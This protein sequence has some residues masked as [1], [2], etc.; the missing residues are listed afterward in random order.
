VATE[1]NTRWLVTLLSHLNK[2]GAK[3]VPRASTSERF[4]ASR[5]AARRKKEATCLNKRLL[6]SGIKL[7]IFLISSAQS[8]VFSEMSKYYCYHC[9]NFF[10]KY[11]YTRK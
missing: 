3:A 5:R 11:I 1:V 7:N 8:S 4:F 6:D 10:M 9:L 2:H